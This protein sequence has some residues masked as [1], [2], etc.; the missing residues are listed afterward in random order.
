[1]V[2]G[3][4]SQELHTDEANASFDFGSPAD[5]SM[6]DKSFANPVDDL[7][8]GFDF[9]DAGLHG[10]PTMTI[11]DDMRITIQGASS[12]GSLPMHADVMSDTI[13]NPADPRIEDED[14]FAELDAWFASGAVE[15]V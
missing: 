2:S 3:Q 12:D 5:S 13:G 10:T 11:E 9:I 14:E 15:I 4:I 6:H 7:F 1:L 8:L